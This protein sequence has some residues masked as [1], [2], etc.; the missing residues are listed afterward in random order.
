MRSKGITY[1]ENHEFICGRGDKGS[2]TSLCVFMQKER[3]RRKEVQKQESEVMDYILR[4][5]LCQLIYHELENVKGIT[6]EQ[7]NEAIKNTRY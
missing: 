1:R 2:E 7:Y 6:K 4:K 3:T 5:C